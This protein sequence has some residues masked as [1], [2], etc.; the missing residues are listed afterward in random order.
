M[1]V[2]NFCKKQCVKLFIT[3]ST[4][5]WCQNATCTA[6]IWGL[7]AAQAVS[8]GS[9]GRCSLLTK[10]PDDPNKADGPRATLQETKIQNSVFP[11]YQIM[12]VDNKICVSPGKIRQKFEL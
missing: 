7:V 5:G 2:L 3:S 1:L 11:T 4:E 9:A 8:L 6:I 10:F 12:E